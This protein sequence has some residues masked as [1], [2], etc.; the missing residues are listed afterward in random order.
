[1]NTNCLE[2]GEEAEDAMDVTAGF[3]CHQCFNEWNE[4]FPPKQQEAVGDVL[5]ACCE[6][7]KHRDF[8]GFVKSVW[9]TIGTILEEKH[10]GIGDWE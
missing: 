2:C 10:Q 4:S 3:V 6:Y 8:D 1:M 7:I 9:N 5:D